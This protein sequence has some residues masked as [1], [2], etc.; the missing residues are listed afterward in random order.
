M[1][2]LSSWLKSNM[3]NWTPFSVLIL[4]IAV[5]CVFILCYDTV[6]HLDIPMWI[7]SLLSLLL[8]VGGTTSLVAHGTATT[9]QI[10]T[11]VA[12]ETAVGVAT[13]TPTNGIPAVAATPPAP[14]TGGNAV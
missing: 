9:A 13:G 14:P 10:A 7:I 11:K 3:T 8:G 6:N 4:L 2:N 5:G 12:T 1:N